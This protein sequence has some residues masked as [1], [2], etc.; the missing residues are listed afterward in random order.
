MPGRERF[1]PSGSRLFLIM[2]E[3][4]ILA[5]CAPIA[6]RLGWTTNQFRR[7]AAEAIL[8]LIQA[9]P[10]TRRMPAIV[11]LADEMAKPAPPL[12]PSDP[13]AAGKIILFRQACEP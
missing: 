3:K 8:R 4:Q 9:D 5:E 13:Q 7:H 12:L 1:P 6:A 11:S 2:S 10:S